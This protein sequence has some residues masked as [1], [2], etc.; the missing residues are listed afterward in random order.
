MLAVEVHR[1]TAKAFHP[2]VFAMVLEMYFLLVGL[3]T[4]TPGAGAEEDL[5]L[6]FLLDLQFLHS[7]VPL[8]GS[9]PVVISVAAFVADIGAAWRFQTGCFC[10]LPTGRVSTGA[11]LLISP[12]CRANSW[13]S[14]LKVD[15]DSRSVSSI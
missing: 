7:A 4:G 12:D 6:G 13:P 14:R 15:L 9:P 3:D 5:I 1:A 11:D 10:Q 8:I 2:A